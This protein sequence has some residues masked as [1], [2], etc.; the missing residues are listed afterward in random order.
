[1]LIPLLPLL[2]L[3]P[4]PLEFLDPFPDKPGCYFP[5]LVP[6]KNICTRIQNNQYQ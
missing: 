5:R 2:G 6:K 4:F 3:P 1:M